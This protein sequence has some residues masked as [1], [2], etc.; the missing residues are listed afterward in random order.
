MRVE[1]TL[2]EMLMNVV[3]VVRGA[4]K[5]AL[6]SP[7]SALIVVDY[8]CGFYAT[9]RQVTLYFL[10]SYCRSWHWRPAL[11]RRGGILPHSQG[12]RARPTSVA[13]SVAVL[14]SNNRVCNV[15]QYFD[16]GGSN[17]STKTCPRAMASL[18]RHKCRHG[19]REP[20]A[21]IRKLYG[22]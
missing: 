21:K 19:N 14:V 17:Q 16:A 20:T 15:C 9:K 8:W 3:H 7:T 18:K 11:A 4:V 10:R 13:V 1:F 22:T 5:G 2:C 6:V 12:R